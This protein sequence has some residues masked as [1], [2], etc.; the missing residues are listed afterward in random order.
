MLS[1]QDLVPDTDSRAPGAAV[2]LRVRRLVL[3]AVVGALVSSSFMV[4]TKMRCPGGVDASGGFIDANGDPTDIAPT[5]TTLSLRPSIV[6]Y[7]GMALLVVWVLGRVARRTGDEASAIRLIDR[8]TIA[9][10]AIALAS[11]VIAQVWFALIPIDGIDG[12]GTYLWPFPFASGEIVVEPMEIP[13][14]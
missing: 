6:L 13:L 10:G 4:A 14:P 7:L 11:I 9:I 8:T 12:S 5:C 2:L 1:P 3:V